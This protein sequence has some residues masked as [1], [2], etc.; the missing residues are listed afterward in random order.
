MDAIF[1][2]LDGTLLR[3]DHHI[4]SRNMCALKALDK[5][6]IPYFIATGRPGQL[7][8]KILVD[9]DYTRPM[10]L[11]NGSVIGHPLAQTTLFAKAL[12]SNIIEHV[13]AFS[14]RKNYLAMLYTEEAIY[15]DE[16]ERTQYFEDFQ[17][18]DP[19]ALKTVFRRFENYQGETVY[20]ILIVEH[21]DKKYQ[22][23]RT[24]LQDFPVQVAQSQKGFLDINPLGTSKGLAVKEMIQHYDFDASKTLAIGDQEND[25]SMIE[26]V[27][28]FV[29]MGNA[30]D[31]VKMK[32][33]HVTRTNNDDGVAHILEKL[34]II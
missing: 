6:N 14:Q 31:H 32:A 30:V 21:D 16:N 3:D 29:A 13:L 25:V 11:Y 8:K 17:K 4:S 7:V 23:M 22:Y 19:P 34:G 20:K 28:T 18:N 24:F 2:D 15:T 1:I 33:H 10:I 27:G 9:L 5:A 12:D 26:A